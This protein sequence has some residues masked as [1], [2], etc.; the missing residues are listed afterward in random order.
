MT[1]NHYEGKF[2]LIPSEIDAQ[3]IS[4]E[5]GWFAPLQPL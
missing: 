3:F 1:V 4:P 2:N 5:I